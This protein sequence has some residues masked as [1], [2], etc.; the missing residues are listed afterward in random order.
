MSYC[1]FHN[2]TLDIDD[3]LA[4]I[5]EHWS[6][7]KKISKSEL[8]CLERLLEQAEEIIDLEGRIREIIEN[9]IE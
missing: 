2:T 5:D 3:C 7:N 1:R 4:A 9:N 8:I 6:E